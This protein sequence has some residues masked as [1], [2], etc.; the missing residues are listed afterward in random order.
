MVVKAKLNYLRISPRKVRIVAQAIK[1]L[2][3][4]KAERYLMLINKR[5]AKEILKLLKSALSNALQKGYQPENLFIKNIVVNEGPHILKRN[6]PKARGGVGR[7]IKRMSHLEIT[8][9]NLKH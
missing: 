4:S 3:V 2:P 8:L 6:Y 5:A 1:N 9:D 7:I